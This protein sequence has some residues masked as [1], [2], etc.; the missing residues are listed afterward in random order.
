LANPSDNAGENGKLNR[1]K[2]KQGFERGPSGSFQSKK[3]MT[4]PKG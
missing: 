3:E 4:V 2:Q 1:N